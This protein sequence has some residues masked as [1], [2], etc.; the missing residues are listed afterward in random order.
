MNGLNNSDF[1]FC[2]L[3]K[4]DASGY[5]LKGALVEEGEVLLNACKT[6]WRK[7]NKRPEEIKTARICKMPAKCFYFL[8]EHVDRICQF[9]KRIQYV[10]CY[11]EK[12]RNS[13]QKAGS[14][15]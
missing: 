2:E 1:Y 4:T 15:Y 12:C 10:N 8:F 13:I 5:S 9:G 6:D 11:L 14:Q 7:W 3:Q